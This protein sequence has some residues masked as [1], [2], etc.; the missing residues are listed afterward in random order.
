MARNP[1]SSKTSHKQDRREQL[2]Q[3][4]AKAELRKA[5]ALAARERRKEEKKQ[6]EGNGSIMTTHS[7][8]IGSPLTLKADESLTRALEQSFLH[9]YIRGFAFLA[10]LL[11]NNAKHPALLSIK[12]PVD[13]EKI[14]LDADIVHNLKTHLSVFL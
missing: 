3:E 5:Q 11:H 9:E 4:R 12:V 8:P 7:R 14:V 13:G 6:K 2:V 10:R 1:R